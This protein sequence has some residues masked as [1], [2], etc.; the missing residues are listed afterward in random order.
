MASD[1]NIVIQGLIELHMQ[2]K[3]GPEAVAAMKQILAQTKEVE[4]AIGGFSE[5]G[6]KNI[7]TLEAAFGSLGRTVAGYFAAGV[8][9]NFL[10]TSYEGFARTERQALATENQIRALG[11]A[12]QGAN[13]RGF[14]DDLSDTS[15]ILDDEL[16]PAFQRALGAF[17]DYSASVE[18]V[19]LASQFAASGIGDVASNVDAIAR[20]FQS[21]QSRGLV[22]FGIDIKGAAD[23]TIDLNQGLEA[24][25]AQAAT[26]GGGFHDAQRNVEDLRKAVDDFQDGAGK[27]L[28]KLIGKAFK[29]GDVLAEAGNIIFATKEQLAQLRLGEAAAKDALDQ[30]A[31]DDFF[32]KPSALEASTALFAEKQVQIDKVANKK[33]AEEALKIER[34]KQQKL[35]DINNATQVAILNAQIGILREG[36]SKRIELELALLDIQKAAAIR[37]VVEIQGITRDEI[38]HSVDLISKLFANL[39]IAV[40]TPKLAK[41]EDTISGEEREK[42]LT[43]I[44]QEGTI[45]RLTAVRDLTIEGTQERLDAELELQQTAAEIS[46]QRAVE[47][48]AKTVDEIIALSMQKDATLRVIGEKYDQWRLD[49]SRRE[50]DQLISASQR[51]GHALADL[52]GKHKSW[53]IGMAIMDTSTAIMQTWADPSLGNWYVKLAATIALAAEGAVQIQRIRSASVSGGGSVGTSAPAP[54]TAIQP[55]HAAQGGGQP[56]GSFIQ[57]MSSS[58]MSALSGGASGSPTIVVNVESGVITD[59]PGMS[60]LAREIQ[61]QLS[62]AQWEMR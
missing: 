5:K 47:N 40:E 52:F 16:V 44:A 11:Q 10:K 48:E 28:D 55:T 17:K 38:A 6:A 23:G 3:G 25:V 34:E 51:T 27:T 20:F 26:L 8:V 31:V 15:G 14:I 7:G 46:F 12:T 58:Q 59:Q 39:K 30:K 4:K 37:N 60:K 54:Q 61:R 1:R 57:P 22:Q 21:G 50:T 32:A 19:T 33:K 36:S 2:G 13:F 35:E 45:A 53:A 43:A 41:P 29:F 49:S 42:R 24:L 56:L 18:I 62:N 9:A